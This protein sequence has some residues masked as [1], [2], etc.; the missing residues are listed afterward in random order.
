MEEWGLGK[1]YVKDFVKAILNS[2]AFT[3]ENTRTIEAKINTFIGGNHKNPNNKN[4]S[5][6][7]GE[8]DSSPMQRHRYVLSNRN[9]LT[10]NIVCITIGH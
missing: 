2:N 6:P 9:K 3:L 4:S 1:D 5:N 8:K 10:Y 7:E